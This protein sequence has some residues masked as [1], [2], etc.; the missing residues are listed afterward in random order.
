RRVHERPA[1][2][3]HRAVGR[4]GRSGRRHHRALLD[5][6]R[7]SLVQ[8]DRPRSRAGLGAQQQPARGRGAAPVQLRARA[9]RQ[10]MSAAPLAQNAAELAARAQTENFPVALFVL[11]RAQ[12]GH[13]MAIYGF[14]RLADELGDSA[15]GDRLTQLDWLE[16]E[17]DRAYAGTAEHPLLQKLGP[18]LHALALPRAPFAALIEA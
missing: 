1:R 5:P 12:R 11:S 8:R 2:G 13:L 17:L 16:A 3:D 14:A 4:S 18:S 9:Q 7:Q 10:R 6:R 15:P